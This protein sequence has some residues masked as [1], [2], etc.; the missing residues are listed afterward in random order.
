MEQNIKQNAHSPV[1]VRL[2][3]GD[4][5]PIAKKINDPD[6]LQ[7]LRTNILGFWPN[8]KN[9][10]F[11]A[12]QPVS[13]ERKFF[14]KLNSY[15]YLICVKSD[16]MRFLMMCYNNNTYMV[17]RA[18]RF[19]KVNQCFDPIIYGGNND[20]CGALFDGELIHNDDGKWVYV[21]HDCICVSGKDISQL[22]FYQRYEAVKTTVSDMWKRNDDENISDFEIQTK[23]FYT[24]DETD[25]LK[26]DFENKRIGHKTDGLIFT[27]ALLK[28][29]THTQYTLFKWKPRDL[30]TFDFKIFNSE[31]N[32]S[33]CAYVYKNNGNILYASVDKNEPG[34][35][36]FSRLLRERCPKFKDGDIVECDYN[37][38]TEYYEPV[39]I[40]SDK[41]TPNSLFTVE[42]TNVN[43][44]EN[45]TMDELFKM[46]T[47][48]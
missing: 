47:G 6:I 5:G 10:H 28:I 1:V 34:G 22:N 3:N 25:D 4:N 42:K 27:P 7:T 12:P 37:T 21:I 46:N 38:K 11:P 19:F 26:K 39:M 17:D 45:I 35:E 44:E 30:H 29:G 8:R 13:L 33:Y 24:F 14:N 40:R 43:I 41:V 48:F 18:F 32:K 16:G 9:D 31:D 2:A 15:P 36:I 20:S 23:K